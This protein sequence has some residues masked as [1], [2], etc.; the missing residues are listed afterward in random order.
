MKK[1]ANDKELNNVKMIKSSN[2][3]E[4]LKY[5]ETKHP[6]IIAKRTKLS[7]LQQLII[8]RKKK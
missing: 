2:N 4:I 3:N 8:T 5:D 1:S 6:D 7:L